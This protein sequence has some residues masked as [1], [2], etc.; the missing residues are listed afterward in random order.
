[1][2]GIV[3]SVCGF[4]SIDGTTPDKCPVCAAPKTAFSL[5]E[6]AI[7]VAGDKTTYSEPEKKHIPYISV[8]KKCGLI[9]DGCL[10]VNVKIGEITHPMLAEHYIMWIDFYVDKK[11][12]SRMMLTPE[13]LNPACGLHL[14]VKSGKFTAIE[15]CNIHGSWI[16]EIDL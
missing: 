11:Y 13:K 9:P 12:V 10:D 3:C 8:A 4:I 15:N 6:D 7:K 1:M 16:K 2:K 14:K 5:K